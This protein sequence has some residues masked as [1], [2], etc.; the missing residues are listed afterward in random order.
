MGPT[1]TLMSV[2]NGLDT[3]FPRNTLQKYPV[4]GPPVEGPFYEHVPLRD[5]RKLLNFCAILRKS[6][7]VEICLDVRHP[8]DLT[9][10]VGIDPLG[11]RG[12]R[13][14]RGRGGGRG[15]GVPRRVQ[16][17]RWLR[18]PFLEGP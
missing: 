5:T 17:R 18:K 10:G 1:L 11:P 12:P 15:A 2:S 7:I 16:P 13:V 9:R 3:L 14:V 4:G 8:G 6:I